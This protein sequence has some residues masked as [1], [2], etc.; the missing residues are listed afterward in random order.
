MRCFVIF[1]S[2]DLGINVADKCN[3]YVDESLI[4]YICY[5]TS[6][7]LSYQNSVNKGCCCCCCCWIL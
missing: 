1:V 2:T 6:F 4:F 5:F 3:E 7:L